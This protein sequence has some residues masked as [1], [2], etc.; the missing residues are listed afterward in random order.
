VNYLSTEGKGD[1]MLRIIG[2]TAR[3]M[4]IEAPDTDKTRPTLDRVKESVFNILIPYMADS[5]VLDLFSGSGNLGIEALSRGASKAVFVDQSR[6]CTGIIRKNLENVKFMDRAGI[7]TMP[8]ERAI[9]FL[10]RE[11]EKFDIIFMDPP[12][13]M[14]FIVK[15]LQLLDDFDIINKDGIIACEHQ[16]NEIAPDELGRLVKVKDRTY[17]D[18][19]YSFYELA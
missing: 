3:G 2:G 1:F 12:Y 14:N 5:K 9:P 7:L 10:A 18:T 16:K 13:N 11:G 6:Y 17:G 19:L 15:T 8:V 4:K